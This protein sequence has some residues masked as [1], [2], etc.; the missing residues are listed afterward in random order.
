MSRTEERASEEVGEKCGY[1]VRQA[2]PCVN[3]IALALPKATA[4]AT[5]TE[6]LGPITMSSLYCFHL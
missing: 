3:K 6:L 4:V 1:L 2:R 5:R